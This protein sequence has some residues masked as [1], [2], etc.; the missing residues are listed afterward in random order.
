MTSLIINAEYLNLVPR[1][2]K[3]EYQDLKESIIKNGQL[4]P[5]L[6]NDSN[7][8]IDGFTRNQICE[9]LS[10]KPITTVKKFKNKDDE[11]LHVITL[12]FKR[13]NLTVWQ[14]VTAIFPY[15]EEFKK[16]AK[17]SYKK[18]PRRTNN[19]G[20]HFG[21]TVKTLIIDII[22]K[23]IDNDTSHIKKCVGIL[24][25]NDNSIINQVSNDDLTVSNAYDLILQ[26]QQYDKKSTDDSLTPI[27]DKIDYGE[28]YSGNRYTDTS[29]TNGRP[30]KGPP[31]NIP[32][33]KPLSETIVECVICEGLGKLTIAELVS[34]MKFKTGWY[35]GL[36]DYHY[37][38]EKHITLCSKRVKA[39][40]DEKRKDAKRFECKRC[41]EL[42][43]SVTKKGKK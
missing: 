36:T 24:T 2:S 41:A 27:N 39:Y 17:T 8:I 29:S 5:I 35:Y 15:Y 21:K 28:P 31:R 4:V 20:P 6:I 16:E 10:I 37:F 1:S 40:S 42:Y 33:S 22:A 34:R 18:Q 9:E 30:M 19:I 11:L 13:R 23:H 32:E 38:V 43:K 7:W 3:E 26:K 14:K 12:N 25:Y